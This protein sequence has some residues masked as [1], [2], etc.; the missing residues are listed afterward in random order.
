MSH[1]LQS[2]EFP[3]PDRPYYRPPPPIVAAKPADPPMAMV[4]ARSGD[5]STAHGELKSA[6]MFQSRRVEGT[7]RGTGALTLSPQGNMPAG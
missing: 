7:P 5:S 1:L 6:S 4:S 2:I 3:P